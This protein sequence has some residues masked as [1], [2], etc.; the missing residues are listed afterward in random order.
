MSPSVSASKS[1]SVLKPLLRFDGGVAADDGFFGDAP[2]FTG[3]GVGLG[4]PYVAKDRK[5]A[6]KST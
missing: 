3:E 4:R 1:S 2:G 5:S 6:V